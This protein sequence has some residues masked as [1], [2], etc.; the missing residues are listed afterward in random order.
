MRRNKQFVEGTYFFLLG[1]LAASYPITKTSPQP[2]RA[3]TES[4]SE[5]SACGVTLTQRSRHGTPRPWT[6]LLACLDAH[7]RGKA[8]EGCVL[9]AASV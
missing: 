7:Y 4:S 9:D 5:Q 6:L 1:F 8:P 2:S 3:H